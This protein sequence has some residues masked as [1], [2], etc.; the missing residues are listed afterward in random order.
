MGR[1]PPQILG[2]RPPSLP[3]SPPLVMLYVTTKSY[4][5][6]FFF[7]SRLCLS[8]SQLCLSSPSS[9]SLLSLLSSRLSLSSSYLTVN[10]ICVHCYRRF[11]KSRLFNSRF[12]KH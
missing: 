9:F 6:L 3:R 5:F 1:P 7:S 12:L 11:N 10:M 2:D 4:N 8:S